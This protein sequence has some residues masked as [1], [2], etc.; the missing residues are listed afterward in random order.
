MEATN[1]KRL[2][3]RANILYRLRKKGV[4][5]STGERTIYYPYGKVPEECQIGRLREEFDFKV[6]F[7]I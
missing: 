3:R 5:C 4:R 2:K 7:F 1:E 6:Q